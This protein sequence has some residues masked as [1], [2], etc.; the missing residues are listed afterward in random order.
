MLTGPF[1]VTFSSSGGVV[2]ARNSLLSE[3]GRKMKDPGSGFL[4]GGCLNE[5]ESSSLSGESSPRNPH[6]A[7]E[8]ASLPI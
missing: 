4:A 2:K 6:G 8:G 3:L 1:I 5:L 7:V